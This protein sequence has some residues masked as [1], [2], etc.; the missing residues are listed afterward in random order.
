VS[1]TQSGW[2]AKPNRAMFLSY[3]RSSLVWSVLV[4]LLFRSRASLKAE[5]LIFRHQPNIQ[6]WDMPKEAHF[7]VPWIV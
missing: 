6:R 4:S 5:I 3:E 1:E 7:S 2:Q